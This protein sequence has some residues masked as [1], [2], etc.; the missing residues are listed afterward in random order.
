MDGNGGMLILGTDKIAS[1]NPFGSVLPAGAINLTIQGGVV[2]QTSGQVTPTGGEL[3]S[4]TNTGGAV[5]AIKLEGG[6]QIRSESGGYTFYR[7]L[8]LGPGGG[9]LDVGAWVQTCAGSALSGPGSLTKYGRDVLILDNSSAT[10]AGGTMI[11]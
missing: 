6:G 4:E 9:S 5:L 10:R 11:R 1:I 7:N 8:V 3:G 2:V